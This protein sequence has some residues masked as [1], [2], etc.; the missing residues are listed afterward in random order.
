MELGPIF[1]ALMHNKARFWLITLEVALTLAIV[2]N[3]A[4]MLMDLRSKLQ[5]PTGIDEENLI[6]LTV[7]AFSADF[8][9][10]AFVDN[11]RR[12]DLLQLRAY[13]GVREA[14]CIDHFPLAGSGS[15]RGRYPVDSKDPKEIE[16]PF[17]R[18]SDR[19]LQTLGIELIQ[20]RDFISQDF[21]DSQGDDNTGHSHGDSGRSMNIIVTED[22]ALA[23]FPDGDALG[24][25]IVGRNETR[26][27]AIVG[28]I[29]NMH[30]AWPQSSLGTRL[31]L[32]PE[33]PGGSE[34]L[35][36]L[37]RAEPGALS[38][39]YTQLE[40][41]VLGVQRERMVKTKTIMEYKKL[42]Y[43]DDSL[44]INLLA[45]ISV[46]LLVVTLLGIVGL[47]SFSVTE[48]TR[49]IGTRRALGA[50]K[51]A[52]VRYFLVENWIITATGYGI[53]LL[54]ALG[55][56]YLLSQVT[57]APKLDWPLLVASGFILWSVG[58]LAA[59]APA[60]RAAAIP[61]EMA[62]RSV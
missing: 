57:N 50:S 33:K 56:N 16:A 7:D 19:A 55:L 12:Q 52:I 10:A 9:D 2:I 31:T 61:P 17:F 24:K 13:P 32:R 15:S 48:R 38:T 35:R 23:L 3:C 42:I 26:T 4:T 22:L 30:N 8:K 45:G 6:T 34:T 62:T 37:V 43:R 47:T 1:R 53:G 25:V 11:I 59:L 40:E 36:Y 29:A 18:V 41:V 44:M 28:I 51:W 27:E 60:M 49:Q 54:L 46:M 14:T 20:G 21:E 5:R 39:L 58:L